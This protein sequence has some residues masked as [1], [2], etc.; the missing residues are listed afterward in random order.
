MKCTTKDFSDVIMPFGVWCDKNKS[1]LCEDHECVA[2]RQQYELYLKATVFK[3]FNKVNSLEH[4][5]S[6]MT[7]RIV[8]T[9]REMEECQNKYNQGY[10]YVAKNKSGFVV[11][12]RVKPKRCEDRGMWTDIYKYANLGRYPYR[13]L[14]WNCDCVSIKTILKNGFCIVRKGI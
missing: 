11:F 9:K 8:L 10:R 3:Y 7:K 6:L 13:S 4:K 2:L 12:F 1:I 5:I 14:S